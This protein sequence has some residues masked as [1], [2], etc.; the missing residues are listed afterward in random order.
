MSKAVDFKPARGQQRQKKY[1]SLKQVAVAMGL[2]PDS[3]L[4]ARVTAL[5]RAERTNAFMGEKTTSPCHQD[6]AMRGKRRTNLNAGQV[7]DSEAASGPTKMP[8]VHPSMRSSSSSSSQEVRQKVARTMEHDMA[9]Q[10]NVAAAVQPNMAA[11]PGK[12]DFW[13]PILA[14]AN[15][16]HQSPSGRHSE[17]EMKELQCENKELKQ[18]NRELKERNTTLGI[19][20]KNQ[21]SERRSREEEMRAQQLAH[22]QTVNNLFSQIKALETANRNKRQVKQKV[23]C[24]DSD[25]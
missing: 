24:V 16:M 21:Q 13:Q 10:H 18:Q 8:H 2:E 11:E 5:A 3:T 1:N 7:D 23:I 20:V 17:E 9:E 19:Q 4:A 14:P 22:T 12:H 15:G 6:T 25:D